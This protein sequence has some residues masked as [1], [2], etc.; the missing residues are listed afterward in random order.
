M[1]SNLY[2]CD[3]IW[4]FF[5]IQKSTP[6]FFPAQNLYLLYFKAHFGA[7]FPKTIKQNPQKDHNFPKNIKTPTPKNRFKKTKYEWILFLP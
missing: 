4:L 3:D 7:N 5:P 2:G 1:F 6:D